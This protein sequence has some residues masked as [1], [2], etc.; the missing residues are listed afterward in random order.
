M[1]EPLTLGERIKNARERAGMYQGKL[2]AMLDLTSGRI[3]SNWENNIARPDADNLV[4]LCRALNVSAAYI[5]GYDSGSDTLTEREND[6]LKRYRSLDSHGK[7]MVDL[8][9]EKELD[10]LTVKPAIKRRRRSILYY[11]SPASAGTGQ[12]LGEVEGEMIRVPLND[13]TENADYVIPVRGDS[14]EPMFFDGDRVGVC[15]AEAIGIGEI[16]IFVINDE[17]YIKC[18]MGDRLRSLNPK[19][20][21]IML[22]DES[23]IFCR[24]YVTGRVDM[25]KGED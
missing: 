20:E 6:H 5:L 13:A 25:L 1:N 15:E 12:F 9:T 17:T 18:Y 14:M 3:I 23:S 4:K 19:Y 16:G 21:D 11:D 24:G 10:R 2:A 22:T 7:D 8:V